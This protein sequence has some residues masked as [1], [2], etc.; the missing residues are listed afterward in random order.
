MSPA[1]AARQPTDLDL[2]TFPLPG[3]QDA[4]LQPYSPVL[5]SPAI[6]IN[7]EACMAG[8]PCLIMVA[9]NGARRTKADHP[10]LPITPEELANTAA[11][12]LEAGAAAIHLHVR[13]RDGGH[14][15]DVDAYRAALT[16]V[17]AVVG[18]RMVC[19]VTTESVGRYAPEAQMAMVRDLHPEAVS[20]AVRELVPDAAG[21]AE[22]ARFFAWMAVERIRPQY[23]L[24]DSADVLRFN[25]LRNREIIPGGP[26]FLLFVLGRYTADQQSE[27]RDLLPFLAAADP[28]DRWAMCAFGRRE[29]VCAL[30]AAALGG[31]SRVG[32]ENNLTLSTGETAPDNAASVAEAVSAA[33]QVG[34]RI[35]DA[36]AARGEVF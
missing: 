3:S 35:A 7:R 10:A 28:Q 15:L 32:F 17:R 16:A 13:D 1:G 30:T 14:T 18:D 33:R 2:A 27:P 36:E 26:A 8:E 34:R 20:L 11:A 9:P 29:G 12:C 31:H 24:Y 23:I 21:E 25:D 4:E 5:G 19:Q 22:A 6:G